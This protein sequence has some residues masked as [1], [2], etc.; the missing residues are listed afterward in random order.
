MKT[1]ISRI[2]AAGLLTLAL[3]GAAGAEANQ[4]RFARQLGLGYLQFYV[5]QD[6]QMV[7]RAAERAGIGKVTAV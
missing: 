7:E 6:K 4:V 5:M 1:V 2:V 3:C